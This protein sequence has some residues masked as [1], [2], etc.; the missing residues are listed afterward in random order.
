M[1]SL[2][3]S[4]I[5]ADAP[6]AALDVVAAGVLSGDGDTPEARPFLNL[7]WGL[8]RI[9]LSRTISDRQD[10]AI[11]V[12]DVGPSDYQ[13]INAIIARLR[14]LLMS[15]EDQ[16]DPNGGR[17][18]AVEWSGDSGDLVDDGHGTIVRNTNF[19]LIGRG[20]G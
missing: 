18:T 14:G 5:I 12:H 7:R 10:L 16:V 17:V 19:V 6:L 3:Y 9:G 20:E 4:A 13:R 11:W 2:V 1:R 8:T 15:I